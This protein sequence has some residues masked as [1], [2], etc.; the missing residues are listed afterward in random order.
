MERQLKDGLISVIIPV[1]NCGNFIK[2]TL[3][4][5][6]GQTAGNFEVVIVDDCS[7][8]DSAEI[9]KEY[10]NSHENFIYLRQET[11][12]GVAAARNRALKAASGRYV[13]FLDSDDIWLP[14]KTE[15]QQKLLS[16]GAAITF[17]AIEMIDEQGKV[18][19]PKRKVKER[20]NY[21]FL[22]KNTM[23]P[24]SSVIVDRAVCGDFN[25]P[26]CDAE[27]YATWL[28]LMRGGI[29]ACGVDRALVQ[30]RVRNNSLSSKKTGSIKEVWNVQTKQERIGKF[31]AFFNV[32]AFCFNAFKK[33]FL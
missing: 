6:L 4:S 27:D 17:T 9:A 8:D 20:V 33:H 31:R 18:I 19:K 2:S 23:I 15:I 3:D 22:L 29:D 10:C 16:E 26:E 7:T 32:I 24:T 30:Y 14:E 28:S 1:Y 5:V 13:A 21:K 12:G 25:M 11:N